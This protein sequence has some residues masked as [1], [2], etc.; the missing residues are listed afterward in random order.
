M[1]NDANTSGGRLPF[2][3]AI[4]IVITVAALGWLSWTIYDSYS[5]ASSAMERG[6]R[7][8][9]LRGVI[10]HDDE[11]LTTSAQMA[12]VTGDPMWEARYRDF[13]P[14]LDAAIKEAVAL[15]PGA[16]ASAA[17]AQ[18]DA[19]NIKLVALE[20]Q[21]FDLVRAGRLEEA[22]AVLSS[23]EYA[24]QKLVYAAGVTAFA[25]GL[26]EAATSV[27]DSRQRQGLATIAIASGVLPLLLLVWFMV[28]RSLRDWRKTLEKAN[29]G[30]KESNRHLRDAR[31][32]AATDGF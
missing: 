2:L 25:E 30:L 32:L 16:A 26:H 6:F 10:I 7:I 5:F 28:W 8:E 24:T 21:V 15:E 17:S 27:Q 22:Q 14:E 12:T 13:E 31:A 4:A 11:V 9:E 1:N 29:L 18:I 23:N 20:N 19:A 3:L